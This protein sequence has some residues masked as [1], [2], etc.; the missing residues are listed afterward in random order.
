MGIKMRRPRRIVLIG[1]SGA[2][3]SVLAVKMGQIM[4]IPVVHLDQMAFQ[5]G[6]IQIPDAELDAK[7][8]RALAKKAWVMD[9]N[10]RRTMERRIHHADTVVLLDFPR[11]LCIW[12]VLKRVARSYG[13]SRPDMAEG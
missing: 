13:R 11:L 2:G 10:Y 9:G 1:S 5:P 8:S 4:G 7:L 3:K 12:R 6:W